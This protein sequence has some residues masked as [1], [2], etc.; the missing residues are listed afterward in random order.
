MADTSTNVPFWWVLLFVVLALGAGAAIVLA[1]G[2][3]LISGGAGVLLPLLGL[4]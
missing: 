1:V 4:H 2:G 3:S